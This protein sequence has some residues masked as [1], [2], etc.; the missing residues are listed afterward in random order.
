MDHIPVPIPEPKP[1]E[2]HIHDAWVRVLMD[3]GTDRLKFTHGLPVSN[4]NLMEQLK[5]IKK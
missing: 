5:G 2:I 4:N 1:V 3:T